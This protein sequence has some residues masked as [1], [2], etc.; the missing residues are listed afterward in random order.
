MW[1]S[2]NI[3]RAQGPLGLHLID[4]VTRT[5]LDH[6]A[7]WDQTN[8]ALINLQSGLNAQA[9]QIA[10]L[11]GSSS[12][13]TRTILSGGRG[14]GGGNSNLPVPV[15]VCCGGTGNRTLSAHCV[16]VGEGTLPVTTVGPGTV[17]QVL[18]SNGNSADPSFQTPPP[19]PQNTPAVPHQWLNSY[20]STTGA[21]GQSQPTTADLSD[22]PAQTGNAA[23]F[24]TT[25]GSSLSWG[26]ISGTGTVT[27]VV[28][29]TKYLVRRLE[30]LGHNVCLTPVPQSA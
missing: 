10:A 1:K 27:S 9:K 6:R 21:F 26:T 22:F 8:I 30:R 12:P 17:G 19:L 2:T 25:D 4:S 18:T 5:S 13:S 14:P 20:S 28:G 15:P 23:K 29:L 3:S 11:Q 7:L 24:L 16:L